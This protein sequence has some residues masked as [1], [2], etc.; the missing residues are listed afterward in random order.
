MAISGWSGVPYGCVFRA[1]IEGHPSLDEIRSDGAV[2]AS[3]AQSDDE[4]IATIDD[5]RVSDFVTTGLPPQA[6]W[7]ETSDGGWSYGHQH[8]SCRGGLV[9][10]ES[11][12][13]ETGDRVTHHVEAP[14]HWATG[15]VKVSKSTEGFLIQ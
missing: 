14:Y 10:L 3:F 11:W 15:S 7:Q 9:R 2:D 1:S 5:P 12:I 13:D 4:F 6:G 8:L